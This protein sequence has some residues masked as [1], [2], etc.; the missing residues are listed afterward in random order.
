MSDFICYV[1]I[2]VHNF[3]TFRSLHTY[4]NKWRKTPHKGMFAIHVTSSPYST[5]H[6]IRIAL[7]YADL[8]KDFILNFDF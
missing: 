1:L 7:N 4:F 2:N 6:P 8:I 5:T 3:V